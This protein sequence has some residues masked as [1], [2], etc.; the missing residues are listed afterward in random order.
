MKTTATSLLVAGAL[1]LISPA[2]AAAM[3]QTADIE[4]WRASAPAPSKRLDTILAESGGRGGDPFVI[5]PDRRGK[6]GPGIPTVNP[7]A[8]GR[9]SGSRT[10][11]INPCRRFN[12]KNKTWEWDSRIC[13]Q[14][15]R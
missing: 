9:H 8:H 11:V 10:P 1:L 15:S 12:R 14:R 4:P 7:D 3:I 13:P 2:A 6:A 5:D